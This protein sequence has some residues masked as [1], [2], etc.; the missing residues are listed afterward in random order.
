MP[1]LMIVVPL[2]VFV[3]VKV[4]LPAPVFTSDNLFGGDKCGSVLSVM[5]PPNAESPRTEVSTVSV[6]GGARVVGDG[7]I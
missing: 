5:T 2:W 6:A 1:P 7:A 3:P 4:S